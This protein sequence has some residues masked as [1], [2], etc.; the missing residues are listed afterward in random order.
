MIPL[1]RARLAAHMDAV[2][3]GTSE[4]AGVEITAN[5]QLSAAWSLRGT[6]TYLDAIDPDGAVE[7]RRPEHSGSLDVNWAFLDGR[8]NL[9]V[10]ALFN[11][12]QEDS[13]FIN[14]TPQTRVTLD[15]YTLV[16]LAV[17]FDVTDRL[18]LFALLQFGLDTAGLGGVSH[19][20]E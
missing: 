20:G 3:A 5:A 1:E 19:H 10:S 12:E 9:N 8:G 4:R 7:V 15:G 16:N 6:Y 2:R 17:S 14:A 18:Q 13:E 11:G